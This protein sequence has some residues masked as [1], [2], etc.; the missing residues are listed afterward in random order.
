MIDNHHS[1]YE[2]ANELLKQLR[3]I[4]HNLNYY[5]DKTTPEREWMIRGALYFIEH[6]TKDVD[7]DLGGIARLE[8]ED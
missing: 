2:R 1:K 7:A 4:D 5:L 8:H 6:L 3:A